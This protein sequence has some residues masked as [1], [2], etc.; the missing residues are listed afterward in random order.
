MEAHFNKG[1]ALAKSNRIEEARDA[2]ITAIELDPQ[3]DDAHFNLGIA[4]AFLGDLKQSEQQLLKT[5][6]INP[7]HILA[8]NALEEL[9]KMG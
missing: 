1:M 9:R 4:Y 6:E 2:F 7:A 5:L 8:E 3:H